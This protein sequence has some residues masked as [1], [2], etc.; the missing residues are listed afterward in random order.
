MMHQAGLGFVP[1]SSLIITGTLTENILMGREFDP[2]KLATA[3]TLACL[4]RDVSILPHGLDT[5]VGERGTTL[6]GGQQARLSIA[7]A[8][9]DEP[10]LLILD[11]PLAAV[12]AIVA[13]TIFNNLAEYAKA[14]GGDNGSGGG[15]GGGGSRA[16]MMVMNQLSLLP[17]CGQDYRLRPNNSCTEFH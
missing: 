7:R 17:R 14:G 15:G 6:S 5:V 11:D 3:V 1:Q 16:V 2:Q 9:Y 8:L 13:K 10:A 12:D 4:D